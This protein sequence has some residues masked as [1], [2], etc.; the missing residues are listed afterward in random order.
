MR[1]PST[2][3]IRCRSALVFAL[4]A[5]FAL[6]ASIAPTVTAQPVES[7]AGPAITH[8]GIATGSD[9]AVQ[10]RPELE[11]GRLVYEWPQGY[12]FYLVVEARPGG[13]ERAVGIEA[14]AYDQADP[15]ALPDVQV[16]LS[17]A[18]GS[19]SALVCEGEGEIG[20]PG[21]PS[22]DFAPTQAVAD[23][24]NDLGCRFDNGDM[25][26]V[27]RQAGDDA[28]TKS[29][30]TFDF[31]FVDPTTTIQF[32]AFVASTWPFPMGDTIVAARARD[33]ERNIGL[34]QEIVVRITGFDPT[35]TI[36]ATVTPTQTRSP[37]PP[38]C[39]G[40]CNGNRVVTLDEL[41]T[42]VNIALDV[43]PARECQPLDGDGSDTATINELTA[44]V[45]AALNGCD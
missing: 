30:E 22:L 6:P 45:N 18:V 23:A 24:V 38:P 41:I 40:D 19:G 36:T 29:P 12:G 15:T 5:T 3:G 37:A 9:F 35:P 13:S 42:G 27:G 34:R 39:V 28:C 8:L 33:T 4:A 26:T 1:P 31:G 14:Y 21:M 43:L 2:P 44:A 10:P 25:Q 20:I 17:Q 16:L 11:D 7:D 32:C